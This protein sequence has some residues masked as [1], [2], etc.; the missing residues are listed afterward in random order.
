[1]NE[2]QEH[3]DD[4]KVRDGYASRSLDKSYPELKEYLKEG[5]AVLDVGCGPGTITIGVAEFVKPGRDVKRGQT[6]KVK[7]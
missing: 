3:H 1:M 2:L 6:S 7:Y 5:D 4:K